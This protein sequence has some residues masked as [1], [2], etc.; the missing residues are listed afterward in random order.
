MEDRSHPVSAQGSFGNSPFSAAE[1]AAVQEALNR[2]LGIEDLSERSG[3]GAGGKFQYLEARKAIEHA[4]RCF[5]F[6]GWSSAVLNMTTDHVRANL[7]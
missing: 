7:L 6:N 4:N 2:K 5:G 3:R 1:V